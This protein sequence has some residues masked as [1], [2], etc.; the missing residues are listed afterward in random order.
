M[1]RKTCRHGHCHSAGMH[2][3]LSQA[4]PPS[5]LL[6]L[7]H[8]PRT[9][10]ETNPTDKCPWQSRLSLPA[11]SHVFVDR[12]QECIGHPIASRIPAASGA[13]VIYLLVPQASERGVSSLFGPCQPQCV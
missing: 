7:P 3:P 1:T 4:R 5:P 11:G 6:L 9:M 2:A 10:Y 13:D 8:N 12:C